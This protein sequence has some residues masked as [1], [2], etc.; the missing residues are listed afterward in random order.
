MKGPE[1]YFPGENR[2][3]I[4]SRFPIRRQVQTHDPETA[5]C[6]EIESSGQRML[7]YGTV[8]PYHAA[9]TKYP[10]RSR[11]ETVSGKKTWQLHYESIASHAEEWQR[12]RRE[13]PFHPFVIGGDLNQN[14]DG[15]R[16][17]G[18]KHGRQQ[19]GLALVG[20]DLVCATEVTVN[21]EDGETLTPCIDHICM[22]QGLQK[23]VA[24]IIGWTAGTTET[25]RRV[26]DHNGVCVV[27]TD[28]LPVPSKS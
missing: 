27:L 24:K 15:R 17:Y 20:A 16:W 18:T 21:T 25:G 10:Y 6:A 26:S 2:T 8:L 7:I 13:H 11:G 14:R 19:L 4:W 5:V 28:H 3:T 12:L 1:R 22:D 9:G 23:R